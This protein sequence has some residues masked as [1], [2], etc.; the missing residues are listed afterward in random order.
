MQKGIHEAYI[1]NNS[2]FVGGILHTW[3]Q[4][5]A[6]LIAVDIYTESKIPVL[7]IIFEF[8]TLQAN[9]QEIIR[10]PVP[11]GKMEEARKIDPDNAEVN[12]E[13]NNLNKSRKN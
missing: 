10:I 5:G 8:P 13:L 1:G 3:T 7:H 2:A 11:A 4:L 6:H 9:Q 12:K